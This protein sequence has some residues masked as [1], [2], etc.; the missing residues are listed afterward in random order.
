V[1]NDGEVCTSDS[2][3]PTLG[4]QYLPNSELC[5]DGNACTLDDA[6]A[7]SQ[8]VPGSPKDCNDG[9]G[10][11]ADACQPGGTCTSAPS[12]A[13]CDDGNVCTID[14]CNAAKL[15]CEHAVQSGTECDDGTACTDSSVCRNGRCERGVV[16]MVSTL[17]GSGTK[18]FQDGAVSSA[19]FNTPNGV[20]VLPDGSVLVGDYHNH[21][22]RLI[23]D[24]VVSTFAGTGTA[25]D[26]NGPAA[27]AQFRNPHHLVR[28]V[29]GTIYVSEGGGHRIRKIGPDL[30][31]SVLAGSATAQSGYVN[32]TGA[33]V[34]FSNP[35]QMVLTPAGDILVADYGNHAIRRV[36]APG[37]A[38]TLL[39]NG[40]AGTANGPM[41]TAT[42]TNPTGV[43]LDGAGNV[44]VAEH[45]GQRI[46]RIGVDGMVTTLLG[47][48]VAGFSEALG[49]LGQVNW[50]YDVLWHPA[51]MLLFSDRQNHRLRAVWPDGSNAV[52]VG[53]ATDGYLDGPGN[54]AKITLPIG[55][56]L[57]LDGKL[58]FADTGTHRIR[59]AQ[60]PWK[61]CDDGL[62]CTMDSC[63][64]ET[65]LCSHV[66]LAAGQ[67]CDD[68]KPCTRQEVCTGQGTCVGLVVDCDD[69]N[70]C[71]TD[72]CDPNRGG[73]MHDFNAAPCT[74][75]D[76]CTTGTTCVAGQCGLP[77]Y[78]SD[79]N[80]CT[81]DQCVAGNCSYFPLANCCA[82]SAACDDGNACTTD[83]CEVPCEG[84]VHGGS[85]YRA[86]RQNWSWDTAEAAC[87]AWG[88]H[89]A[90]IAS[91]AENAAVVAE[92]T[93][94]CA[95]Q[96]FGLIGLTDGAQEAAYK[97]TDGSAT[98][99]LNWKSGEPN[100]YTQICPAGEDGGLIQLGDGLW[101]DVCTVEAFPC[102]VC[103]R[104]LPAGK[105]NHTFK[106]SCCALNKDCDDGD[107]CTTDVCVA[108]SPNTCS[109]Q[110]VSNCCE[111]TVASFDFGA[112][113]QGSTITN[114]A[115][116]SLGWQ[117]WL[118]TPEAMSLPGTLYYG[119]PEEANYDFGTSSGT[120]QWQ[121]T[122]PTATQVTLSLW[123]KFEVE[124]SAA[125]DRVWLTVTGPDGWQHQLWHKHSPAAMAGAWQRW[126]FDLSAYK[127]KAV[128]VA[129]HVDTVDGVANQSFGVAVD[130]V[131][132][133]RSCP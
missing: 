88:G 13:L 65:G 101:N 125:Y 55:L 18:S 62:P 118:E 21:R 111:T 47:N 26:T 78:C 109:H 74:D 113:S 8:C 60:L 50:P 112:A 73:C 2:C 115:G 45:D 33:N 38:S 117:Q 5:S 105:C 10:C 97:W 128:T 63:N 100:E 1:C 92:A 130:D 34:R 51:G 103:E 86:F 133:E 70:V 96:P 9:I 98:G 83:S 71:T 120:W 121:G 11:T 91:G 104:P 39:G 114:S 3:S 95:D 61:H 68:G 122:L 126:T 25:G 43:A 28:S 66:S 124:Q 46:R 40:T 41:R 54:T 14:S 69:D 80:P 87:Q 107:A 99:Y 17:A 36:T 29:D 77:V 7:N 16:G 93:A 132:V 90:S 44:F 22:I 94:R 110:A 30:T 48:G 31:V 19:H 23:K 79:G 106:P 67:A 49:V 12:A 82:N 89:L 32:G 35:V 116:T 102:M 42:L 56:A 15:Y 81:Q 75:D 129:L 119:D 72:S 27:S 64:A 127:G 123:V 20:L 24:G 58:V 108:G 131:V 52:V 37:I 84:T 53:S 76:L 6:C 4:C 59:V 85:C 57:S